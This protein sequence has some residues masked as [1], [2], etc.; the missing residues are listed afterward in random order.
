[1]RRCCQKKEQTGEAIQISHSSFMKT[2]QLA[3]EPMTLKSMSLVL[4]YKN[5][6]LI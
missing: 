2:S 4:N 3:K 1:M 5:V 6:T